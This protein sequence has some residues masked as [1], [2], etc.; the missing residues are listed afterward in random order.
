MIQADR[1]LIEKKSNLLLLMLAWALLAAASS[2]PAHASFHFM[3]V[4]QVVGGVNGNTSVQALQLRMRV[5]AQN[6]LQK[7]RLW[8]WDAAGQNPILLVDFDHPV[9]QDAAGSRT[10]VATA[11]FAN[12]T[13]PAAKPDFTLAHLIPP[14]YLAAGCIT[15]EKDDGT[16]I[17]CRLTWGGS[18]YTGATNASLTNDIDGELGP[19][20]PGPLP[21]AD[22][23]ALLFQNGLDLS[24]TNAEDYAVTAGP[25][26]FTNNAG[27]SFTVITPVCASD[28]PE[29]ADND[30]VCLGI[31]NCPEVSNS[32]Q[33]DTDGDAAGNACDSCPDD[34]YK[35]EPGACG[36]GTPDTDS[37][38]NGI[39]DCQESQPPPVEPPPPPPPTDGGEAGE[40]E[41]PA[42]GGAVPD[43]GGTAVDG[44]Q[45]EPPRA[46]S[47][48]CPMGAAL[49]GSVAAYLVLLTVRWGQRR[50]P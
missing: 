16:L 15:F 18:N 6:Q 2:S 48:G 35:T 44:V 31:D 33:A 24:T 37:D 38:S 7:T 47:T 26:V 10:L 20:F 9:T 22:L 42:D 39:L 21:S 8:A 40:P 27:E 46:V 34:P 19:P 3:H 5:N 29:D 30:E 45:P 23:Q 14:A 28:P 36:C 13:S 12:Y 43:Q 50:K 32:D 11:A 25:A 41:L 49:Q 17:I 4:E 1:S